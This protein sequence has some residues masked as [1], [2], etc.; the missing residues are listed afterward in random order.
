MTPSSEKSVTERCSDEAH[1]NC[2][3][4]WSESGE[5]PTDHEIVRLCQCPCHVS[6]QLAVSATVHLAAWEAECD[7]PGAFAQ[8]ASSGGRPGGEARKAE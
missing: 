3:H 5:P 1:H 6:C 7:C 4:W 2:P 8:K